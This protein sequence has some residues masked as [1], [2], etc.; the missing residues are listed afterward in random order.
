[1]SGNWKTITLPATVASGAS[2]LADMMLLLTDGS[3]LIHNAYGKE[4]LRFQPDSTGAYSG[5]SWSTQYQ[6]TDMANTREYFASGILMDGRVF[7]I[8]GED[9]DAGTDTPLGEIF[10]PL[11]NTWSKINKPSSFDFICGD[12]N[13]SVLPDGR[14]LLGAPNSAAF[15]NSLL[16]AIWDPTDNTWVQAGLE[17]GAV[18][19][20]TKTD[21]FSE[22]TFALMPDGSVLAPAVQNTPQAQRYVPSLD[23]W[24]NCNPSPVNL[25]IATIEGVT[26][27][28]TGPS[29][30]LPSGSLFCIGGTGQTA[31]FTAP[32]ESNPTGLG[33]WV[34]GPTCPKDTSTTPNWPTLTALDAPACLL[35]NGTVVL[36]AGT[37]IPDAGY[38]Y[39]YNPVFFLYD[40][41]STATTLPQLD[42]QPMLPTGCFTWQCN[43]LLLP[44]GQL[45]CSAHN[46]P[47]SGLFLYTPDPSVSAPQAAWKPANI[48]VPSTLVLGRSYTVSGTQI[49]G[50]SQAVCY[51]DDGGMATNYPIVQLTNPATGH[52]QYLRSYNFSSMGVATGTTVPDDLESCTIDI[53]PNLATGNWNLVVIANGISSDP[54]NVQI[55]QPPTPCALLEQLFQW[56]AQTQNASLYVTVTLTQIVDNGKKIVVNHETGSGTLSYGIPQ[57]F[58]FTGSVEMAGGP[59]QV[60]IFADSFDLGFGTLVPSRCNVQGQNPI[61]GTLFASIGTAGG[62]FVSMSIIAVP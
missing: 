56:A 39:S 5:R 30:L 51:G 50:L 48:S 52:V 36:M 61:R 3:I 29:I 54:V 13:G 20:T 1:M 8:G 21:P 4:W 19:T 18:A 7:A 32:P 38:Y 53:P 45:L 22:E 41:N 17:F 46:P 40:P 24:V 6:E 57:T 10:D 26:E 49:N 16:T 58:C 33:S 43:F 55:V 60:T 12:C 15:P 42:V 14:A 59:T 28:E 47:T 37:A 2:F 31:I 62:Y 23:Q 9:S 34:Q 27:N 25:A 11:T 35:P 44:T